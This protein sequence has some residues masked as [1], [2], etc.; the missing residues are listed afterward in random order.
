MN[1]TRQ[2]AVG[3]DVLA[4]SIHA[5]QTLRYRAVAAAAMVVVE[6]PLS[7]AVAAFALRLELN[8]AVVSATL[9]GRAHQP[10]PLDQAGGQTRLV[11]VVDRGLMVAEADDAHNRRVRLEELGGGVY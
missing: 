11:A 3:I 7:G 10:Q 6:P 9:T 1:V 4:D 5:E 8:P 2:D